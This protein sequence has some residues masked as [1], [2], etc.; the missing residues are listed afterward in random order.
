MVPIAPCG[1]AYRGGESVPISTAY[2]RA[3]VF[4]SQAEKMQI[5]IRSSNM[6]AGRVICVLQ[7]YR[8]SVHW[9]MA[10]FD[11]CSTAPITVLTVHVEEV[12]GTLVFVLRISAKTYDDGARV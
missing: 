8:V 11:R 2:S 10:L 4:E 9:P 6:R 7:M 3:Y 5:P 1:W 12:F